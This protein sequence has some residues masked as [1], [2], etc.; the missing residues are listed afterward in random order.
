V[1]DLLDPLRAR[2]ERSA[3]L[4]DFDGTLSPIVEDW[5]GAVP[6]P[7]TCA[8]LDGLATRYALV[9]VISGRPVA[10]L[11]QHLGTRLRLDGLYG[12][13]SLVDGEHRSVVEVE[14]WRPK[15][16]RAVDDA[17]SRFG[18]LVEDKGLS[19]T[20]HFRTRPEA[21]AEVRSWAAREQK[22]TG[23]ELRTAKASVELHPP[24]HIDKGA[25][26]EEAVAGLDAVCFLGDDVGDLPAF[27]A[28][29]RLRAR[30]VHTVKIGVRTAES[31]PAVLDASDVLVE[32][33][34]GALELLKT[35]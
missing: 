23:L 34:I 35:L 8:V 32:G 24:V 25:V 33:P 10:Y 30:G 11:Q 21:E 26:V 15:V 1:A 9:G 3:I 27:A 31:P 12:L 17:E 22:R 29:D 20:V 18:T 14:E 6:L 2:P 7:E 4:T 16:Q 5:M 28:L 13:E 19:M